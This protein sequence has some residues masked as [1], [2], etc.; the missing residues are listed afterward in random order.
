MTTIAFDGLTIA[1]DGQ[2]SSCLRLTTSYKKLRQFGDLYASAAGDLDCIELFFNWVDEGLEPHD[3]PALNQGFEGLIAQKGSK[4]VYTYSHRGMMVPFKAPY[5]IGSG[6]HLAL[7][8]MMAG[9]TAE[10]AIKI[11]S[12]LDLYTGGRVQKHVVNEPKHQS[13]K[14]KSKS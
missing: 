10:Q 3:F 1:C 4:V 11:A 14:S 13:T 8:A 6:S 9:A 5:A 12:K 7:G 2:I